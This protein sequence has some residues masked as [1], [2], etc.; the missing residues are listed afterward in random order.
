MTHNDPD[1]DRHAR[2]ADDR[3]PDSDSSPH[4]VVRPEAW[5]RPSGY[6]DGMVARGRLVFV[7]GQV[8]WNPVDHVFASDDFGTQAQAALEN[9][10]AVLGAAGAS[11]RHVVRMTWFVTSIPEYAL[12]RD[13]LGPAFRSLFAG[14]YPTISLVQVAGLLEPHA[15]VEIEATAVIP[16]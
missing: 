9:V 13:A 1:A 3:L 11:P 14:H 2:S 8:G 4:G 6:A 12:A 10:I 5:P 15:K 16:E 7:A